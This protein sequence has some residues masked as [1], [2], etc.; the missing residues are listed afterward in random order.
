MRLWAALSIAALAGCGAMA[1]QTVLDFEDPN[2]TAPAKITT[3]YADRGVI[4]QS[5]FLRTDAAA[6]SPTRVLQS[7]NPSD[8]EFDPAPFLITF[9]SPQSRVKFFANSMGSPADHV[10]QAFDANGTMVAQDGPRTVAQDVFTT[11]FEVSVPTATITRVE[12]LLVNGGFELID[13]LEFEGEPPGPMPTE[14]PV[15]QILKP[16]NGLELDI[17]GDI[18]FLEI[19]GTATGDGL[20]SPVNVTLAYKQPPES[21]A[22]PLNLALA[23]TATGTTRT[24]ELP[25]GMSGVPLGPITVTATAENTGALK[26]SATVTFNNLP[27]EIRNR[28]ISEGGAAELGDFQFGILAGA[29]KIAVYENAAISTTGVGSIVVRGDVFTKWMSLRTLSNPDGLGCPQNEERDA[30]GGSRAQ[31]FEGG[32]ICARIA[33]IAPPGVAYVP[34][35][36]REAIDKRGTELVFGLPMSDPTDSSGPASLTWLFQR[37]TRGEG[38]DLLPSTLEIRHSPPTLYMER[39]LGPWFHGAF[40]QTPF[41]IDRHKSPATLWESFPCANNLGPCTVED[42]PEFPPPNMEDAG[43]RFCNGITYFPTLEGATL[44]NGDVVPAEWESIRGQY[45]VTPVYGAIISA[46]M[47]DIDNGFTHETHNGNCPYFPNIAQAISTVTCV[48]DFEFFVRPIGPQFDTSPLP[49]LFG[50][51]NTDRIKTEYEVA[52]AALAHNFL[53]NPAVGD[54]VHTTGRWII[55]C[56]HST[57][58]SELHPIFSYAK[59]KTVISETNGFTKLEDDLFNGK[60]ATRVAI[61]VN[62]WFPGGDNNAI[63][64]DAFPPPRPSPDAALHVVKPVDN[65]EGGFT[66]A[67]DVTMEFQL[68]PPG[69]AN[70]VHLKF[71]SPR[72]ENTVTDAGEMKFQSGRQYWGIWYLYWGD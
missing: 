49:S 56:G 57:Y 64:F 46:H 38:G 51:S 59:M 12:F 43:D 41:D 71:T 18:P 11:M 4:F 1:A 63:E 10:L 14:P 39:Q 25:G 53:G 40:A 67:K 17:P 19:N 52:F 72:R 21:T 45:D 3:Q 30:F 58:K 48:S 31:D 27:I 22:P 28:F 37:F 50:K 2:I 66:A 70:R 55:D 6:H 35:V 26:G 5:A 23:L 47:T 61:W 65:A 13:D 32:R 20:I 15:V 68:L 7:G 60:P 33:G 42:E 29:C 24:F 54:L 36:F 62:G 34:A 16:L 8:G 69:T 9:T 44:P